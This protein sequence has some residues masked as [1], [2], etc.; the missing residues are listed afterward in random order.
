MILQ[1]KLQTDESV[2]CVAEQTLWNFVH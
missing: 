2:M 1:R